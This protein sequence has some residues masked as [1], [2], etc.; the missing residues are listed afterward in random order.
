MLSRFV[1]VFPFNFYV[2]KEIKI[3]KFRLKYTPIAKL[4]SAYQEKVSKGLILIQVLD[5]L[6]THGEVFL[7]KNP[8]VGKNLQ[9]ARM[10]QKSHEHFEGV[11]QVRFIISFTYSHT[12]DHLF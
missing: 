7:K 6:Q 10:F 9:K 11:A 3:K 4:I 5:W 1:L 8:G 2:N 12:P